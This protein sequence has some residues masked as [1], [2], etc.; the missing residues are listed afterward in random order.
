MYLIVLL[1]AFLLANTLAAVLAKYSQ[2]LRTS[3]LPY[4][5]LNSTADKPT[6]TLGNW[7]AQWTVPKSY[8]THFYVVGFVFGLECIVEIIL[9][10]WHKTGPVLSALHRFDTPS[11]RIDGID[12]VMALGLVTV[13]L[14]RRAYESMWMQRY[15]SNGRIHASHY[16]VGVGFYV[17]MV[18]ATWLEGAGNL[19]VYRE[20]SPIRTTMAVAL[21]VYASNHQHTCHHI[22]ASL[23]TKDSGYEIPRGDWFESVVVPH[24]LADILIYLALCVL[25]GFRNYTLACGLIWTTVNLTITAGE[26]EIWYQKTF[27][28]RYRRAFPRGRWILLP[29]VY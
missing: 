23:R 27:G 28:E 20:W 26:T 21:F 5:K 16:V 14:G 29:W 13:H 18:F 19:G 24:Y 11:Y 12:G 1:C 25:H 22:L 17:C 3:V 8:F 7:V 2:F 9:L 4:G 15:S 10:Q 6:S